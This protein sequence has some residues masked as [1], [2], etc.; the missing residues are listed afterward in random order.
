MKFNKENA[1]VHLENTGNQ[2]DLLRQQN[3]YWKEGYDSFHNDDSGVYMQL[4]RAEVEANMKRY[5]RDSEERLSRPAS[6][7][8]EKEFH[9]EGNVAGHDAPVSASDF[10]DS[11][12]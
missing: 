4:P 5:Q 3:L 8:L 12:E 1:I 7:G 9:E 11:E 6:A 2:S 10:L